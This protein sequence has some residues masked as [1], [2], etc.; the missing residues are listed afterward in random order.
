[1]TQDQWNLICRFMRAEIL[2]LS[3]SDGDANSN[4]FRLNR[5]DYMEV[6]ETT[7]RINAQL[8]DDGKHH[9]NPGIG[10]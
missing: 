3:G 7:R 4:L 8:S 2:L 6:R 9:L 10:L 5:E 1:M